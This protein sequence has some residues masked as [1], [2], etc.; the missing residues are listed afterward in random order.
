MALIASILSVYNINIESF[1]NTNPDKPFVWIQDN[2]SYHRSKETQEN[3]RIRRIPY[4]K[5]PRYSPDLNLIEYV[6]N[7]M[8][9]WIQKYYYT[10]YYNASKIPLSQLRRIIWEVWEAVPVDFI[11]KL[12]IL[13]E[14]VQSCNRCKRRANKVLARSG[15]W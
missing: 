6:W 15:R 5:W 7:W 9:N 11:I 4:I 10:V 1:F 12:F 13:V 14:E 3:L 2:A 8:K